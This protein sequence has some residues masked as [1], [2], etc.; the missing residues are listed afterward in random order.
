MSQV[1]DFTFEVFGFIETNYGKS[2]LRSVKSKKNQEIVDK[3]LED[4]RSKEYSADR[5][6]NKIIAMLRLNP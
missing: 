4:S 2:C 6:A 1:V 5:T 3:L